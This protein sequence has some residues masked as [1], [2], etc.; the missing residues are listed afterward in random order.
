MNL[1][2]FSVAFTINLSNGFP[3]PF[4][5]STTIPRFLFAGGHWVAVFY[6]KVR[7]TIQATGRGF[8]PNLIV[9][10]S[11]RLFRLRVS[12]QVGVVCIIW[13]QSFGSSL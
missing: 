4:V 5:V 13:Y 1:S 10:L 6:T 7:V 8:H 12:S 3:P 11:W 9:E 2:E